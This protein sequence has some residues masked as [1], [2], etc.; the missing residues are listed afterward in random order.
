MKKLILLALMVCAGALHAQ[1]TF[2]AMS[3]NVENLFD[4]L[5]DSLK[6]DYQYL[7][8]SKYQWTE[9]RYRDKLDRIAEVI[10]ASSIT[11]K[12]EAHLPDLVALCEVENDH[13][14]TDLTRHSKLAGNAAM[15]AYEYVMTD[16]P[17]RRGVDVALL[18]QPG[19]FQLL[20][21]QS[22]R[23]PFDE[24]HRKPTRDIL[25]VTGRVQSGDTLDVFV[26]HAPSRAG[27]QEASE[28]YRLFVCG[29]LRYTADSVMLHR[30]HPNV[31]IMGDF[32]DYPDNR[33]VHDVLGARQPDKDKKA[34]QPYR[35]YNLMAGREGG[36]Y[37]YK[38]EWNTL[39]H[40]IVSGYLLLGHK[41]LRTSYDR[42]Q[43]LRHPFLLEEDEKYGGDTPFRTYYG[44][45]YHG[46]YSDHLPVCVDFL[47]P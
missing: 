3:Y 12:R 19:S 33:S 13:C 42:A 1:T 22:I 34:I 26:C 41:P 8:D 45:R 37:R 40:I 7:P 9:S 24:L 25:H 29:Q 35:L 32:N 20:D 10:V 4:C 31:L 2:R 38:G 47:L 46:G 43:F 30:Q 44:P 27:G 11:N 17:D 14:L 18:Y 5:H 16:S 28:F 23:V 15:N 21:T 6:D 36:S 39:D